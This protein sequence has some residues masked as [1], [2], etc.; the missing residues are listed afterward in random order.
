MKPITG[1]ASLS[2][3]LGAA[4][5]M[6]TSSIGPGFMLQT[7]AFTGQL[8]ADFAFAIVVSVIFSIIAQLNVWTI[9]GIS[10]MRGQ[11]IANKVLPGLGYFVAFLISL[12][13]LAFN[14]GNIGGASMGL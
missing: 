6:A 14:I 4:F 3:L 12:G 5:L 13:G 2:V 1:K 11:D 8:Q 9:I 7:A 10:Q